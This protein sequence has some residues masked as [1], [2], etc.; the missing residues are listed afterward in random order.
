[1]YTNFPYQSWE[2][3]PVGINHNYLHIVGGC[4]EITISI[5]VSCIIIQIGCMIH[6]LSQLAL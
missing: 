5:E 2:V 6:C 4:V 1:M 3:F